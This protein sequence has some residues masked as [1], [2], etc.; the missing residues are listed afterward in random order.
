MHL[1]ISNDDL[2]IEILLKL[3]IVPLLSFKRV[4]K[5]WLSL[6]TEP[7]FTLRRGQIPRT[8]PQSGIL[9]KRSDFGYDLLGLSRI[10]FR[11][12]FSFDILQSCNGL[13][14]SSSGQ[15]EDKWIY[16]YKPVDG[17]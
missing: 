11:I 3:T 4:S 2:L 14:L 8:D 10:G 15:K 12:Y 13:L 6:I 16:V 1:V 17:W 7:K 5:H 9:V